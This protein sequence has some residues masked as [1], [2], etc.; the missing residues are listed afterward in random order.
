MTKRIKILIIMLFIAVFVCTKICKDSREM[1]HNSNKYTEQQ[2]RYFKEIDDAISKITNYTNIKVN[3]TENYN[4]KTKTSILNIRKEYVKDSIF[5][6]ENYKPSEEV[7]GKIESNKPWYGLQYYRCAGNVKGTNDIILG[8][9]EESRYINN[10]SYLIG[11]DC[12]TY[13]LEDASNYKQADFC[14]NKKYIPYPSSIIYDPDN[15]TLTA[16]V[17][18]SG[19]QIC[20]FNDTNARDLGYNYGYITGVKNAKFI[21]TSNP[22]NALYEFRSYV[23]ND[24]S[25]EVKGGCNNTSPYVQETEI[26]MNEN[27]T[28]KVNFKLWHKH[29][30]KITDKADINYILIIKTY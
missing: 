16:T 9:S 27:N 24:D 3:P 25:C 5:A 14:T 7:Y 28:A 23:H 29:P 22:S 2:E 18:A 12:G 1:F 19:R 21:S 26:S 30:E 17:N 11:I 8:D 4:Y 20:T 6:T 13:T 10:P 15:N